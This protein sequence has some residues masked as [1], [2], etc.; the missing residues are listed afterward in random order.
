MRVGTIQVSEKDLTQ[1]ERAVG[2]ACATKSDKRIEHQRPANIDRASG[3][4]PSGF[5]A[6]D[7]SLV[8]SFDRGWYPFLCN[9]RGDKTAPQR[10]YIPKVSRLIA[11]VARA[12]QTPMQKAISYVPGGRIF[13][14][15]AGVRR[16]PQGHAEIAVLRWGLPR[17]SPLLC[18]RAL[19][20]S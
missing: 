17:E 18:R 9:S 5:T 6:E 16:T 7:G 14:D 10:W 19:D 13:L 8:I 15:A 12:L 11:Q 20:T 2:I 4:L 1:F 3:T